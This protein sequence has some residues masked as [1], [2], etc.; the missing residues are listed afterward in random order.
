VYY[1]KFGCASYSKSSFVSRKG[2]RCIP[3]M[4]RTRMCGIS[5]TGFASGCLPQL[6]VLKPLSHLPNI[7][8][9]LL[10]YLQYAFVL[11]LHR[12]R[13]GNAAV[14]NGNQTAKCSVKPTPSAEQFVRFFE[15]V[16]DSSLYYAI[17]RPDFDVLPLI[18][19]HFPR[20]LC[21]QRWMSLGRK[22]KM[23]HLLR[24]MPLQHYVFV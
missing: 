17:I 24:C 19:K 22:R 5:Q 8:N 7:E 9:M 10:Q 11:K 21:R 1:Y 23:Q 14:L 18:A 13:F 4:Q 12:N 16:T 2:A 15:I 3:E 20:P 6:R